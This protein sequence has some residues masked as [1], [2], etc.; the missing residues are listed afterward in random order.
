MD[1]TSL[2]TVSRW[3][4]VAAVV[5]SALAAIPITIAA[6][7]SSRVQAVTNMHTEQM[8]ARPTRSTASGN[9]NTT[10][11]ENVHD[12]LTSDPAATSITAGI[13]SDEVYCGKRWR[14]PV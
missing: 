3:A 14:P 13:L 7:A 1:P 8:R 4:S 2:E 9:V 6:Y 5:L 11:A 12:A 10:E